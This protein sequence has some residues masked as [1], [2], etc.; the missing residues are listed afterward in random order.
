MRYQLTV[1]PHNDTNSNTNQNDI[2]SRYVEGI[3]FSFPLLLFC[4]FFLWLDPTP[5]SPI[6]DS[7][8]PPFTFKI[9]VRVFFYILVWFGSTLVNQLS[10]ISVWITKILICGILTYLTASLVHS[11]STMFVKSHQNL[12][13]LFRI[14][15]YLY[16]YVDEEIKK[17]QCWCSLIYEMNTTLFLQ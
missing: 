9:F 7:P 8:I 4:S 2:Y 10:P 12:F 13:L 6:L 15:A 1:L 17:C 3:P 14:N 5:P 16:M 11:C